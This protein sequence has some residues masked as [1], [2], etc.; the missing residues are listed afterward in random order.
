MQRSQRARGGREFELLYN[1]ERMSRVKK[2]A[3]DLDGPRCGTGASRISTL[4]LWSQLEPGLVLHVRR[5]GYGPIKDCQVNTAH[6]AF[7]TSVRDPYTT[8]GFWGFVNSDVLGSSFAYLESIALCGI[9]GLP[10]EQTR[11]S[12]DCNIFI[13][14]ELT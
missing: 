9:L 5:F 10:L 12:K 8:F 2:L 1:L 11:I 3:I 4:Q 13:G 7:L 14:Q 6:S